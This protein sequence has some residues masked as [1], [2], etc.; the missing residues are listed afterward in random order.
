[1][2]KINTNTNGYTILFLVLM[3][4]VVGGV[5]ATVSSLAQPIID[6]N[7]ELDNKSK[8]LASVK[9][10]GEGQEVLTEYNDKIKAIAVNSEGKI[11]KGVDGYSIKLKNEYKKPLEERQLPVF[12]YSKGKQKN[13]ILPLIGLGLWD[14]VNGY[15]A[16]NR[17]LRTLKGAAFDHVGETPGLGSLITE[18]KF[19][20]QFNDAI[21]YT[22]EKEYVLKVWKQGKSP[23]GK[24]NIDGLAGATLTTDGMEN[25]LSNCIPNYESYFKT[26]K[27]KKKK[28]T[29]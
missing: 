16:F 4:I 8:I 10:E 22:K 6:K 23:G 17:D 15:V 26:L 19:E 11:L 12:I 2:S 3:V 21:V 18:P 7:V 13:Y 25:M 28:K 9:F 20:D 5:L 24:S 14:E 1:M 29:K 27:T